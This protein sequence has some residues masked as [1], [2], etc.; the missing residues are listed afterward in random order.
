MGNEIEFDIN[1]HEPR[2]R[3]FSSRQSYFIDI[4]LPPGTHTINL[5]DLAADGWGDGAYLEV[6]DGSGDSPV[7]VAGGSAKFA[8]DL[9]LSDEW[10]EASL[11]VTVACSSPVS[12]NA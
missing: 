7:L 12:E 10:S 5:Y 4:F 9:L 1:G 3:S 11:Q 2:Y 6:M 8:G